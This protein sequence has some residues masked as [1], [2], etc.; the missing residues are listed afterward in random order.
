VTPGRTGRRALLLVLLLTVQLAVSAAP[1]GW[2][3]DDRGNGD[4]V[5][6]TLESLL[7]GLARAGADL[8]VTGRLL[9]TGTQDL[10]NVEVR[11][12]LSD[13]RLNSR[14]ELAAVADGR[15]SSRD[16][17]VV[18]SAG[19]PD[20]GAG[21][22]ETFGLS[23]PLDDLGSL[24]GFGVYVLGVEVLASRSSGFGRV[25]ILR[26][27]LPWVPEEE[28]FLATGFTWLWPLVARPTRL[29]DGSFGDE[30][31]AREMEPEGRLSRLVD[32]G[33]RL[34]QGAALT[35]AVDPELLDAVSDMAQVD[36]ARGAPDAPAQRAYQV[37]AR[38]GSLVPGTGSELAA[39]WL[40]KLRGA[41]VG[42]AVLALP[43]GDPDITA[44]S[45]AGLGADVVRAREQ[46]ASVVEAALPSANVL[47]DTV[48]PVDGFTNRATLADLRRTGVATAVL[49]GRALPT[50]IDLSY[51]PAGRAHLPTRAGRLTGLLA[52]PQLADLLRR[53]GSDPLLGAQRLLAETA[54]ITSELPGTGPGRTILL[55]PPRRWDPTQDYLDRLVEVGAQA[56]WMAPV[57]LTELAGT[58]PP[59]VDR[60]PLRYPATQRSAELPA[61][62]LGAVASMDAS[63][64][65]FATILTDRDQLVPE[66]DRSVLLLESSWWRGLEGR[67]NRL[68][69]ERKYLAD[70]RGSV[71]V[72]PGSFTFSSRRG[73]I[74]LT[75][76]NDLAQDVRVVLR[77]EPQT[78]QLRLK[79][80]LVPLRLNPQQKRQREVD[81]VA[82]AGG[83]VVVDA[84]LQTPGGQA[85]G[86]PVQVRISITD[87]GTVALYI[88]V[89]AAAVLFLT[90]GVQILRRVRA[91]R[92]DSAYAEA[93]PATETQS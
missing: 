17:D 73:T 4:P 6:I 48:W 69:R 88:T 36:E 29:A 76:A 40:E 28:D 37:R 89:A 66:L 59:E 65:V 63:I 42:R 30:S 26:T 25:A 20:L 24:T 39:A 55:M 19:L 77:L 92:R 35:W 2:A 15:T 13:T 34:E 8:Q 61:P 54:M 91:A 78:I 74:P 33:V 81:A 22:S 53:P 12:R 79:D 46:G 60:G 62:Y 47:R 80:T 49:D 23:R 9:N 58:E 31:L 10:R 27:L 57:S 71:R 64:D 52:D 3:V 44:V 51:T 1:A 43:Y 75:V 11:L 50:V 7:P 87:Y 86:Q 21:Q 93:A 45:R 32:A 72:Q 5:V 84:T 67:S 14:S 90:A 70:L 83:Q 16:G 82:V 85:Y 68:D 38:D 56:P 18:V 41:T